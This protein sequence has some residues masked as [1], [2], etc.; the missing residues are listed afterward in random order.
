MIQYILPEVKWLTSLFLTGTE[1]YP[2]LLV[3]NCLICPIS[4][5]KICIELGTNIGGK[6]KFFWGVTFSV[7]VGESKFHKWRGKTYVGRVN[8]EVWKKKG[9]YLKSKKIFGLK[10]I[11]QLRGKNYIILVYHFIA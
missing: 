11:S 4:K 5:K 6:A 7:A 10:L 8:S 2:K 3:L 9:A 1:P